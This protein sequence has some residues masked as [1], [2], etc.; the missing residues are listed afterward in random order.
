MKFVE[1]IHYKE[2]DS[3]KYNYEVLQKCEQRTTIYSRTF[4]NGYL[5]L[6]MEGKLIIGSGYQWDGASGGIDTQNTM[7]ASL[8][9]DALFQLIREK[10]LPREFRKN[11]DLM[12][13]QILR[14]DGMSLVRAKLH[15]YAVRLFGGKFC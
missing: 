15:Y 13:Y 14:N 7:R 5:S 1:G 2:V 11:A 10:V 9:H 4:F 3:P 8:I 12:Y 6:T